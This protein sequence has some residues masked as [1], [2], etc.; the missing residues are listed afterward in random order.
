MR[1]RFTD[2]S[3]DKR[4]APEGFRLHAGFSGQLISGATDTSTRFNWSI[5]SSQI[6]SVCFSLSIS[7]Q[8]LLLYFCLIAHKP[9][10]FTVV[11]F[12]KCAGPWRGNDKLV[13][14]NVHPTRAV[15]G[16]VKIL[17]LLQTN[18]AN[19]SGNIIYRGI[20]LKAIVIKNLRCFR[21]SHH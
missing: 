2:G 13:F 3:A 5:Y 17:I 10:F 15:K 8:H 21:K 16:T 1:L 9:C 6:L 4:K 12:A 18:F 7:V 20:F 11:P 19:I 14:F